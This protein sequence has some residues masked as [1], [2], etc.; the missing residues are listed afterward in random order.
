MSMSEPSS[1]E[2]LVFVA[3]STFAERD[4]RPLDRLIESGRPYRIHSSGK[5]ITAEELLHSARDAAVVIAGVEPYDAGLLSELSSLRCIARCGIG[6][7]S[8]DL[9]AA[10]NRGIVV[11]NTPDVPTAAVAELAL[12]MMLALSRNLRPQA[13]SMAARR[14]E[15]LEAHL[16]SSRV[17]GLIGCGRIG[18]RVAQLCRAFGASVVV[19]DPHAGR[20]TTDALGAELVSLE[21]LLER[22]DIVSI[23]AA[24]GSERPLRLGA[25]E[26]RRMK[27]GAI[28]VN[29][30]RGGMLDESGLVDA[31]KSGHLGGAGLDV[32]EH[33]P[34]AGPLCDFENVLLT[35]HSATNPVETRAAMELESVDKALRF[36]DG[37]IGDEERVA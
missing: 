17:V 25:P 26:F 16:F 3:L 4:R 28:I 11:L 2:S 6:V 22:A 5:R 36:L 8:I 18:A 10:R 9:S 31:L 37:T 21:D 23:H 32:Y 35:P 24:R 27:R 1:S 33:E 15:R 7:D 30:A 20:A 19:A 12:A 14:W 29:L 34:Y 13:A